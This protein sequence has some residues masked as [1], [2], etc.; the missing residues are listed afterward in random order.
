MSNRE[1]SA[2]RALVA[3]DESS[4]AIRSARESARTRT[5]RM[6]STCPPREDAGRDPHV[7]LGEQGSAPRP[8]CPLTQTVRNRRGSDAGQERPCDAS[9]RARTGRGEPSPGQ[10]HRI[11]QLRPVA[12]A[13]PRPRPRGLPAATQIRRQRSLGHHSTWRWPGG[14]DR[15]EADVAARPSAVAVARAAAVLPPANTAA[16]ALPGRPR[17]GTCPAACDDD[18]VERSGSSKSFSACR[19]RAVP[20]PAFGCPSRSRVVRDTRI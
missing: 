16:Q 14:A 5:E 8:A 12:T 4:A 2:S 11:R 17:G 7:G 15:S 10:R 3:P 6:P 20:S 13:G 1:T 9:T 19:D 18:L